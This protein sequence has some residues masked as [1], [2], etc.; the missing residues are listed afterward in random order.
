MERKWLEEE[1][2]FRLGEVVRGVGGGLGFYMLDVGLFG[3]L[4][5]VVGVVMLWFCVD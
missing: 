4:F 5:G 3:C 2:V 1:L